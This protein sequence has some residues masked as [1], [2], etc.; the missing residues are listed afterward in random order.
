MTG[1]LRYTAVSDKK[2]DGTHIRHRVRSITISGFGALKEVT[3]EPGAMTALVGSNGAGKSHLIRALQLVGAISS[4]S[5]RLFVGRLGGI[6][7][8]LHYGPHRTPSMRVEHLFDADAARQIAYRA[9]IGFAAGDQVIFVE[10][11][12]GERLGLDAPFLWSSLGRGHQESALRE[13]QHASSPLLQE[14]RAAL[15]GFSVFHFHD[16]SMTAALRIPC[17]A[18]DDRA[19]R[20]DGA[21]LPAVLLRLADSADLKEQKTWR[22]INRL[23]Q[24]VA[25]S[26]QQLLPTRLPAD[27]LRL[28]WADDQGER[29]SAHQ[30]SDGSLRAIALI[31]TLEQ[32]SAWRPPSSPSM[33]QSLASTPAPSTSS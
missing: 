31:T 12:A 32:P 11:L 19:L 9:E 7:S 28:D 33:S 20:P 23:V 13:L 26:V 30:L 3:L 21:N 1:G 6:S 2:M 16:T 25:P 8:L 14:L 10:E 27:K 29:F 5:L 15:G 24:L 22:I 4:G 18:A 17:N